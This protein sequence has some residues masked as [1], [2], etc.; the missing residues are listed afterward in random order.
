[1]LWWWRQFAVMKMIIVA[2]WWKGCGTACSNW[3]N[4]N[5]VVRRHWTELPVCYYVQS[6]CAA[7]QATAPCCLISLLQG[8]HNPTSFP[9]SFCILSWSVNNVASLT[10]VTGLSGISLRSSYF[11]VSREPGTELY[12]VLLIKKYLG[13]FSQSF[14]AYLHFLM[15][16]SLHLTRI[17]IIS[18]RMK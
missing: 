1:M 5:S 16:Y 11:C 8:I 7:P 4:S 18:G 6:H 17:D 14:Y 9:S 10:S 12:V 13:V 3:C 2:L 15:F